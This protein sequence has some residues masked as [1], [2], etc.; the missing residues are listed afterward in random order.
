MAEV[1]VVTG[2]T[3]GIGR[4]VARQLARKG[5]KLAILAGRRDGLGAVAVEAVRLGA[6]AAL[7]MPCDIDDQQALE[8]ATRRIEEV[9]GPIDVWFDVT[10]PAPARTLRTLALAAG[11]LAAVALVARA[12]R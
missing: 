4:E 9:L 2:A 12:L 1:V 5:A 11:V 7:A 10:A 8:S 6:T 3:A